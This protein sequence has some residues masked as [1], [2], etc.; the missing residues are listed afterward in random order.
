MGNS[1]D[2]ERFGFPQGMLQLLPKRG[3]K[4]PGNFGGS[5][6]NSGFSH[7]IFGRWDE[8]DGKELRFFLSLW[9]IPPKKTR[10][11]GWDLG[12]PEPKEEILI[13][14]LFH[15]KKGILE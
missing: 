11:F 15:G 9:N 7:W 14:Q 10:E 12:I 6:K 2:M 3:T 1:M 13:L 5:S 8:N 4:L